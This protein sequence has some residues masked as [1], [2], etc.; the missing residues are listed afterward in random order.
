M[1]MPEGRLADFRRRQQPYIDALRRG[2]P[3]DIKITYAFMRER[4]LEVDDISLEKRVERLV[5][6]A[7]A[8]RRIDDEEAV[9]LYRQA[10]NLVPAMG[11]VRRRMEWLEK[12][13]ARRK[14]RALRRTP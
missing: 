13:I 6:L 8:H 3:V 2:E 12:D 1:S 9:R 14:A 7:E 10:L 11:W 5:M 4:F